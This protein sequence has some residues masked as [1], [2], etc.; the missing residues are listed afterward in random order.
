MYAEVAD[1][2]AVQPPRRPSVIC[3]RI[4]NDVGWVFKKLGVERGEEG[5]REAVRTKHISVKNNPRLTRARTRVRPYF[6]PKPPQKPFVTAERRPM[7]VV[8][9]T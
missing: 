5:D 3:A 2:R 8:R 6:S 1:W 7:M 4:S 9:M